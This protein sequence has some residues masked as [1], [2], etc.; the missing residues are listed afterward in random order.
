MRW[1]R[2]ERKR[3]WLTLR[4][5]PSIFLER[6]RKLKWVCEKSR[7]FGRDS[8]LHIRISSAADVILLLYATRSVHLHVSE[9]IYYFRKTKS[10]FEIIINMKIWTRCRTICVLIPHLLIYSVRIL[11]FICISF[12]SKVGMSITIVLWIVIWKWNALPYIKGKYS[13]QFFANIMLC[14]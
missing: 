13:L 3:S 11:L 10:T 4:C 9:R 5:Y 12:L 6:A 8:R 2:N 7:S 14:R 1:I